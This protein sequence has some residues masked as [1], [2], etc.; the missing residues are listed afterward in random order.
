MLKNV[1]S[2]YIKEIFFSFV[3]EIK[4]LNLIRYNKALQKEFNIKLDNSQILWGKDIIKDI[5]GT[6]KMYN[7]FTEKLIFEGEY[8][9]GK[10][11]RKM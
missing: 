3:S 11:K 6:T 4:Q 1:K 2:F 7:A 9:N 5:N 10:K 8:I